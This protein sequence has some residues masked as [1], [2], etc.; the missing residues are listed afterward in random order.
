MSLRKPT[1]VLLDMDG[2][3]VRHM[4]PR[5]LQCLEMLDDTGHR[6]ARVFSRLFRRRITAP[7]LVGFQN[8]KRKKLLVHRALHKIRRKPV[9]EIV[10]PCPGV[11]DILDLLKKHGVR[12]GLVSSGMGQ[13]YGHDVLETFDLARYFDVTVFREDIRRSKPWPDPLLEALASLPAPPGKDDVVWYIGDRRKDVLAALAA[14]E[15]LPCTVIPFAYTLHAAVAILE[16]GLPADQIFM[17]WPDLEPKLQE[18][19]RERQKIPGA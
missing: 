9:E 14:A 18:V 17:A 2:T 10:E 7:P 5:L 12:I 19:L 16:N 3:T 15:H 11:Y 4:N 8:G 6:V 13:G 1:I